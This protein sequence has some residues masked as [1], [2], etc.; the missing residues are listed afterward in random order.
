MW[1]GNPHW[2]IVTQFAMKSVCDSVTKIHTEIHTDERIQKVGGRNDSSA[3][4]N[5]KVIIKDLQ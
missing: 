4:R 2:H 5:F 3:S 1:V